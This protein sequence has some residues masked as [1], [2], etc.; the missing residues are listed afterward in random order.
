VGSR[1]QKKRKGRKEGK[2]EDIKGRR[3]WI[4]LRTR[5]EGSR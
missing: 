1:I 4:K 3:N 5:E 2:G